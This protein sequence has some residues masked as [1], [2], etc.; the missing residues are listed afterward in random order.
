MPRSIPAPTAAEPMTIPLPQAPAL[1]GLS[2]SA[3]YRAAADGKITLLKNGKSTLVVMS[4]VRSFLASLP[5]LTP[6]AH[7]KRAA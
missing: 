2:R 3:I 7:G 4:T 5:T 6:A 1:T